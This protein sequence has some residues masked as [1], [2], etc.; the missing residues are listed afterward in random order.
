MPFIAVIALRVD[1]LFESAAVE[2]SP[3]ARVGA[4][5]PGLQVQAP[6]REPGHVIGG[7]GP[8]Q[9]EALCANVPETATPESLV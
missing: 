9:A 2:K 8:D 6:P 3:E 4:V 5:E 7:R 1:D